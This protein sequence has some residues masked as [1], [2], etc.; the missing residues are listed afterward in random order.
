LADSEP[1]ERMLGACC[2]RKQATG[3][4]SSANGKAEHYERQID[5][6]QD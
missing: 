4:L 2:G 6:M 3:R 1:L 5:T